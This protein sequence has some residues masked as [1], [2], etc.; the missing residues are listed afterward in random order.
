MINFNDPQIR[1]LIDYANLKQGLIKHQKD[2]LTKNEFQNFVKKNYLGCPL[3]LPLGIKFF[4][5]KN[6]KH[7]FKISK[8][9]VKKFIFEAESDNYVGLKIFFKYGD[10]FCAG[11]KVK[12]KYIKLYKSILR[13]NK[14]LIMLI[15]KN[16]TKFKTTS[17]QTRNIPHL[18][19]ELIL[20]NLMKSDNK[21]FINPLIGIKKKGDVKNFVLKKVFNYLQNLDRYKSKII[22]A[23]VICNMH[24]AGP[25]EALHHTYIREML[26]FNE[27]TIG[28]DHAGAENNYQPLKAMKFVK[29]NQRRFRISIF[30]HKG[31]YYCKKC[32]KIVIKGDCK[33][34]EL[35]S[36]S[37]TDFRE[38]LSR[39][40]I[41]LY[42]RKSLQKYIIRLQTNLFNL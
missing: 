14:N 20:Q 15:K 25:R 26:G 3:V 17:F 9:I 8:K 32:K 13:F 34:K 40:K 5:Y 37:G 30:Y 36:I 39:K 2:F 11:A 19:H 6:S 12:K 42:A 41:F 31:A 4:D 38:K 35:V 23:P 7:I 22:Y 1:Y 27:F 21:L 10:R 24:Y 28:R 16:N 18:G 33:H 29:K